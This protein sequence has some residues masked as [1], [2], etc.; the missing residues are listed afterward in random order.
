[1][2]RQVAGALSDC[3]NIVTDP[4]G[5]GL[6]FYVEMEQGTYSEFVLHES[7]CKMLLQKLKEAFAD[8]EKSATVRRR[9]K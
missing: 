8:D 5:T 9:I 2:M 4:T 3:A 6:R 1:M 7:E